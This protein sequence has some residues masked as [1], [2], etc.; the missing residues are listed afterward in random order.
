M[1]YAL[2]FSLSE[3][4]TLSNNRRGITSSSFFVLK[5]LIVFSIVYFGNPVSS[6]ETIVSALCSS[7]GIENKLQLRCKPFRLIWRKKDSQYQV[8]VLN[9]STENLNTAPLR[10]GLY[11]SFTDKNKCVKR[12]VTVELKRLARVLD[13][14][15]AETHKKVFHEY[16]HSATNI[17]ENLYSHMDNTY[18]SPSNLIN[19]VISAADKET[20]TLTLNITDYKNKA[21]DINE[22]ISE[23][24]YVETVG[25]ACKDLKRFQDFLYW[26]LNKYDQYENMRLKS[27]QP[28]RF[29][30]T[31]ETHKFDSISDITLDK[32]KLCPIIDQRGISKVSKVVAK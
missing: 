12:N 15:V 29:F 8:P 6:S 23:R 16:V 25:N 10:Y 26:N 18:K 20:C 14:Q 5:F 4:N 30:A 7:P 27:N 22:G 9:L 2:Y 28:G 21:N 19:N 13:A 11:H 3:E 24:R 17:I 31:A 1:K 32:L